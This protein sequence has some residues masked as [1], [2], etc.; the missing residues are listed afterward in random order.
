MQQSRVGKVWRPTNARPGLAPT[1]G[2][3]IKAAACKPCVIVIKMQ[4]YDASLN[5]IGMNGQCAKEHSRCCMGG[6]MTACSALQ[7]PV[8]AV[9]AKN[10]RM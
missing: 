2:T 9:K 8:R 4:R 1:L 7:S 5:K 3:K 6:L 10:G